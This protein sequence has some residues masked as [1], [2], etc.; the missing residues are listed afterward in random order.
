M[1][2]DAATEIEATEDRLAAALVLLAQ[3]SV[4]RAVGADDAVDLGADAS[5]ALCAVGIE[6]DGWRSTFDRAAGLRPSAAAS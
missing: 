5:E 6:A 4:A 3:A 2:A 1:L